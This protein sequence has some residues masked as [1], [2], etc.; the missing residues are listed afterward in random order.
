MIPETIDPPV[1]WL[2]IGVILCAAEMFLP[3]VYLLW[4]GVAALA[5]GAAAWLLPLPI[6]A[7]MVLFGVLAVAALF[8]GRRWSANQ[9]IESDDPLLNDRVGRLVGQ[10]VEVVEAIAH[11]RGRVRVGDGVWTATGE[12]APVGAQLVVI[13]ADNGVLK[14]A[15]SEG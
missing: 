3:G 6:A 9:A 2:S 10:P 1:A 12:D 8:A 7:Q 4:I 14:V 11:G 13:G 5:T 15:A